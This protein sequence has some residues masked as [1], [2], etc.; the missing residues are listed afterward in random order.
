MTAITITIANQKGGVG[1][2]TTAVTIG[3]AL[4]MRGIATLILDA[5]PQGHVASSLGLQKSPGLYRL[6]F[7]QDPI[8]DVQQQARDNLWIVPGDKRTEQAKH[9]LTSLDFREHVLASALVAAP[10][11]VILIDLAP[12]LD[13]LH[14]AALAASDWLIIPT[15]CDHLA[16]DGVNEILRTFAEIA[17]RGGQLQGFN[18]LPT[19]VDR[20]TSE[21]RLQ[22]KTI[23]QAFPLQIWPFIPVDTRL[24][25]AAA[26]GLSILE[27]SPSAHSVRGVQNGSGSHSRI[28]GYMNV[29]NRL[30]DLIKV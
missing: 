5:D 13:I 28:G 29:V 7:N 3:H 9:Y 1:K 11:D 30:I 15:R 14:I 24:R 22:L 23:S 2:T 19:F 26:H 10:Q 6:I 17:N 16:I 4:A 25:E 12:S 20:T 18:I 8:S 27:Y 21:T